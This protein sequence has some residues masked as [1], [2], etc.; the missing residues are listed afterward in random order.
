M[1]RRARA[2]LLGTLALAPIAACNGEIYLG[3][4]SDAGP[5]ADAG[6]GPTTA[7]SVTL[8]GGTL[9]SNAKP[10]PTDKLDLLLMI[11][12]SPGMLDK[13]EKLVAALR[14]LITR[15]TNGA[16]GGP[17]GHARGVTDLH[18]GVITSSLGSFGTD[19][20]PP[21]NPHTDDHAYLLPRDVDASV[22]LTGARAPLHWG[23]ESS[24]DARY[25][26]VAGAT[27]LTSDLSA[28]IRSAGTDGCG[29]EAS[30]ESIYRFLVD[31]RPYAKAHVNCT[32]GPT[33]STCDGAIAVEGVDDE[34]VRERA[35]FL[36]PD[37]AV[38]VLLLTDES[39]SSLRPYQ[40]NWIP[41]ALGPGQ[42]AHGTTACASVPDDVE[43]DDPTLLS[44]MYGCSSC[45][46]PAASGD[47]GC[48]LRWPTMTTNLDVDGRNERAT[49][50][51]ER[52][53][54]NFLWSRDRYVNAF[55]QALVQDSSGSYGSNP[56]FVD[57]VRTRRSVVF[58]VL[59]GVPDDLVASTGGAIFAP[60]PDLWQRIASPDAAQ[61][62]P[63]MIPSIAP[64]A[65]LPHYRGMGDLSAA[66]PNI[67]GNGGERDVLD[68][69]DLQYACIAPRA[70]GVTTNDDC[71]DT[72]Q[73]AA[74][75]LCVASHDGTFTQAFY[76][77]YPG[78]RQ[79][80]V[81]RDLGDAGFAA[82]ICAADYGPLLSSFVD[83]IDAARGLL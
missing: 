48:A 61:R 40:Q 49:L 59:T 3:A 36:R 21:T 45:F 35:S 37:S 32:E 68:G 14:A 63:R 4:T 78:L 47:P 80:R 74:N 28:V 30:L 52:F 6:P 70:V 56:L 76:K 55:T 16:S 67:G 43:P 18:V 10:T 27:Q 46:M 8:D 2:A 12:N 54:F 65:S 79:L 38:A 41:W 58:G 83:R 23:A 66:P 81:A 7:P 60:T 26:G 17:P 5:P 24:S 57:G 71:V 1:S 53:G 42:M 77:A 33:G 34:L 73:S 75:P 29:Y 22:A 72:S 15:L 50:Q 13:Q 19:A 25:V 62:D 64:R 39:D 82:S 31:P 11:D 44:R 9:V 20:C 69:D 51:V